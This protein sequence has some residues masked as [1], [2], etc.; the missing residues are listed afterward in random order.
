MS[1]VAS[2]RTKGEVRRSQLVTTYGVGAVISLGDESFMVAGLDYWPVSE[3]DIHEPRLQRALHKEGFVLPPSDAGGRD[4]PVVRFPRMY[5]C[6]ECERLGL[7]DFFSGPYGDRCPQDQALLVPSRFVV[8]CERGHIDDFP[9]FHWVHKG[10]VPNEATHHELSITATGASAALIDIVIWCS[11]GKSSTMDGAFDRDALRNVR[12]CTGTRPWLGD[13]E[14]CDRI[15][16]TLQRG[17]S[18]VWFAGTR[19]SISIPPWSEGAHKIIN[20]YYR[21]LEHVPEDALHHTI[22]GMVEGKD[23]AHSVEDLV[24]AVLQRRGEAGDT[25]GDDPESDAFRFQ[26]YEALQHGKRETGRLQD[27][28]CVDPEEDLGLCREWFDRVMLVRKLREV[29]VLEAFTRLTPPTP[30]AE[31]RNAPLSRE[32]LTWLPGIEVN[33]EGVFLEL[34]AELLQEWEVREPVRARAERLNQR[35][36]ERFV[37]FGLRPNS[38]VTPRLV[39]IHTLAH[40]LINQW[41]LDC[42]YPASSLRERLYVSDR[43]AGF[44]IYTATSDSAG[45]L[46]GLA[47]QGEPDRLAISL[48]EAVEHAAWCSSDPLCIESDAA[49]VDSLNMA[50]CHTCVLLP[51][52]SCENGN[53]L[54]DRGLVVSTPNRPE[55]GFFASLLGER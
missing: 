14:E 9:Y 26:E 55:L 54:L 19:S 39:L 30:S 40:L 48:G 44:L 15:P 22:R 52:V 53:V 45:S 37:Q 25:K 7:H 33:G 35:Y 42:G 21:V 36:V 8:V 38:E 50:A 2:K 51:E 17:A 23:A 11:C 16:R 46:G 12:T 49:G 32:S 47:A 18:N 3:P 10:T 29:R 13:D 43:M 41:S 24:L 5:F 28:V 6:R 31:D 4:V 1:V 27:F 20:S 34:N